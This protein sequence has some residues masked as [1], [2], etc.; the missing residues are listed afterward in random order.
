MI[1]LIL[2]IVLS[3][4]R[5]FLRGAPNLSL[6]PGASYPRYTPVTSHIAS[7]GSAGCSTLCY[8]HYLSATTYIGLLHF[9]WLYIFRFVLSPTVTYLIH[10]S[11]LLLLYLGYIQWCREA[12]LTAFPHKK[13]SWNGVPTREFLG[14]IFLLLLLN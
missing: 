10:Q 8:D 2:D 13:L 4:F 6:P 7:V 3:F 12:G 14:N 5:D 1:S 11:L 9:A